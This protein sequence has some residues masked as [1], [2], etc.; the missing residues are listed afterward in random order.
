MLNNSM[1]T[2][3]MAA[4]NQCHWCRCLSQNA[5]LFCVWAEVARSA[6]AAMGA[7][8]GAQGDDEENHRRTTLAECMGQQATG[9]HHMRIILIGIVVR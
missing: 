9:C 5:R 6:S 8:L 1:P 7:D 3:H 2:R 4:L